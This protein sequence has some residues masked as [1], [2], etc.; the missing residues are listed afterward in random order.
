MNDLYETELRGYSEKF[1]AVAF[2]LDIKRKVNLYI[3]LDLE[4]IISFSSTVVSI[5]EKNPQ[6]L[7]IISSN[8]F[9]DT[10]IEKK[11]KVK[12]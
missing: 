4:I 8:G 5:S 11:K 6:L 3:H 10:N 2:F 1:Q 7:Q 12:M 9:T